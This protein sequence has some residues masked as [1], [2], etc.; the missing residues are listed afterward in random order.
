[1]KLQS[2]TRKQDENL[3]EL[4]GDLEHLARL[5]Y[6]DDADDMLEVIVKDQFLDALRDE[7]LWLRI[8]QNRPTS[9]SEALEQALELESYQL[10]NRY[11]SRTVW[12]EQEVAKHG[13]EH[14]VTNRS[15]YK[16]TRE[17]AT[18]SA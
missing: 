10:A 1:M 15:G 13:E 5:A 12:E 3:Q 4:A 17:V 11:H 16:L 18:M 7:D 9:M 2:R 14:P 8:R 6:P